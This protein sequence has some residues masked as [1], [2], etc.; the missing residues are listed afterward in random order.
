M[1]IPGDLTEQ[2]DKFSPLWMITQE[3]AINDL[4]LYLQA[5]KEQLIN[6]PSEIHKLSFSR[7]QITDVRDSFSSMIREGEKNLHILCH[8]FAN[9]YF[10]SF[11][12][13]SVVVGGIPSN[14]ERFTL[15]QNIQ[16]SDLL[17]LTDLDQGNKQ[18]NQIK[19]NDQQQ[20]VKPNL[21]ANVIEYLP[22][23][24]GD[25][26][27]HKMISRIK[28]EEEIW[29]KVTDEIFQLDSLVA[30]DKELRKFS[31]YVK[32]IFGIKFVVSSVED[33][34]RLQESISQLEFSAE[35]LAVHGLLKIEDNSK[36]Y[37]IEV[38][39]YLNDNYQ[40]QTGWE[41]IKS[42]VSWGSKTFE[43]QIQPLPNFL[44]EREGLTKESHRGFK[45]TRETIRNTV[46]EKIPLF[47]YYRDLLKWLF[48]EGKNNPPQF[49]NVEI[50]LSA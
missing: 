15:V 6:S 34:Y 35:E 1:N 26:N 32:D 45:T 39:N 14:Q 8:L 44:Y 22:L 11:Q 30:K 41:A 18:L 19:I 17:A 20:W 28:A 33:V 5:A 37:I 12:L 16:T 21:V 42:V 27:I 48:M 47:S 9:R 24:I 2:T 49:K 7:Q 31:R 23:E 4:V 38:K 36:P 29:N 50:E 13:Q 25:L 3:P 43:I 40:K 46:A 10:S